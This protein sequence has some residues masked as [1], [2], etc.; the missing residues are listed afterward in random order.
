MFRGRIFIYTSD[1]QGG[2]YKCT[3]QSRTNITKAK[4]L[5]ISFEKWFAVVSR[6]YAKFSSFTVAYLQF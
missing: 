6:K 4:R 3:I 1:N 2:T 5:K